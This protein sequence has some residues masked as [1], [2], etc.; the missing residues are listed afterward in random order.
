MSVN[1][2]R[3]LKKL[4]DGDEGY[5]PNVDKYEVD[6][7]TTHTKSVKSVCSIAELDAQIAALQTMKANE[8]TKFDDQIAD[9]EQL[10]LDLL[11]L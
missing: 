5:D 7:V 2:A 10:K 1:F 3:N 11:G 9:L 6:N 8:I 4:V